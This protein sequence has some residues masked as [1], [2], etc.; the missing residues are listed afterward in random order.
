MITGQYD[1]QGGAQQA[2]IGSREEE[3]SSETGVGDAIAVTAGD[4]LD[5]RGGV[6]GNGSEVIAQIGTAEA[7]GALTVEGDWTVDPLEG[8]LGENAYRG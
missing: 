7:G 6:A 3:G 4:A 2:I 8:I 1:G 5:G